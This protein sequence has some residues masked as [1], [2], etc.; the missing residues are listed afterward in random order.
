MNNPIVACDHGLVN[1]RL[2]PASCL[3]KP[4]DCPYGVYETLLW[5]NGRLSDWDQHIARLAVGCQYAGINFSISKRVFTPRAVELLAAENG[6]LSTRCRLR[7]MAYLQPQSL[8]NENYAAFWSLVALYPAT[9]AVPGD[10]T[11][12]CAISPVLREASETSFNHKLLGRFQTDR[13]LA[14][15]AAAG[16]DDLLYFNSGEELCEAAYSNVWLV[17]DGKLFTPPLQAPCLP[18]IVRGRIIAAAGK[19]SVPVQDTRPITKACISA[20]DEIFLSSS[21]RGMQRVTAVEGLSMSLSQSESGLL[22]ALREQV[23][24]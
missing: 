9:A 1:A 2:V 11:F 5:D 17:K 24:I 18:G 12:I 15:A 21:I 4:G 19:Q 14:A 8:S 22:S 16:F 10:G 13:D 3:G 20:A 7:L 23:M 6:L